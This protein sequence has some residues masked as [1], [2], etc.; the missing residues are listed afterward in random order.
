MDEV[1]AFALILSAKQPG[2]VGFTLSRLQATFGDASGERT[3]LHVL[4]L[5]IVD[6]TAD[7]R[8]RDAEKSLD[9]LD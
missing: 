6:P 1:S 2:S 7:R 4:E 9:L 3:S 5:N 8:S